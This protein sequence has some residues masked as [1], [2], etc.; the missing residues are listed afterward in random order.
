MTIPNIPNKTQIFHG[1]RWDKYMYSSILIFYSLLLLVFIFKPGKGGQYLRIADIVFIGML[2][3]LAAEG[4]RAGTIQTSS[5]GVTV[6]GCTRYWRWRWSEV[7]QF[8]TQVRSLPFTPSRHPVL[9]V[10][11]RDG[12]THVIKTVNATP[13]RTGEPT[14]IEQAVTALNARLTG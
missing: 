13:S 3:L 5:E 11:A 8:S 12:R 1:K 14:W 4:L 6:Y 2:L 9:V 10:T 7:K